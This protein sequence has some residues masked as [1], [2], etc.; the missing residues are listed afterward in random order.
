VAEEAKKQRDCSLQ[1]SSFF[2]NLMDIATRTRLFYEWAPVPP[3]V[4]AQPFACY[5]R[6]RRS[7]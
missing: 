5:P 6:H 4:A 1:F 3:A 7:N 2:P